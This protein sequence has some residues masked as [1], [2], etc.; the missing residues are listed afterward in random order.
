[1]SAPIFAVVPP[2]S[3]LCNAAFRLRREVFVEEQNVPEDEEHDADDMTA[4]HV[5][6]ILDGEVVGTLRILF[7]PEHAKIGRVAVGSRWRRRGIAAD[8][9]RFAMN[10]CRSQG[11]DRF[12]LG[13]QL[14][15][16]AL[17]ER[18]GFIAFGPEFMDGGMPHRAM[19]TYSVPTEG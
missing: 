19:A 14:D 1:M 8:M 13:A 11:I 7:K 15:K 2:F 5:V 16:I 6:A 12:Y 17:Y 10:E 18:L 9:M 3:T 4:T